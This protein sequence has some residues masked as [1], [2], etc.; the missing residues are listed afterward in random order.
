MSVGSVVLVGGGPGD[1]DL[2][3]VG[4][5]RAIREADVIAYDRLA[6]LEALDEARPDALLIDVG[7]EPH[8]RQT[9]QER[10][11]ELLI[12][13]ALAGRR[14]VRFKG[15]DG[16]VFGRGGEEALACAA[17]GVPVRVIPG[18]SSAIAAPALA[19]IPV[20]HRSIT[21]G[22]TVVSGHVA[23]GDERSTLDW[24]ALARLNTTLVILMG[25]THLPAIASELLVRGKGPEVPAAIVERAGTPGQRVVRA[26]LGSIADAA[27]AHG[28]RPPAIVVVGE[29]AALDLAGV[30]AAADPA[31]A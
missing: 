7:K 1:P 26:T 16:Y 29:V 31:A 12:E 5:L 19:G 17:A 3:T 4:G 22:F 18:V 27:R 13:H 21:Q 11:N 23:P 25:T 9:T 15:G 24:A 10:I 8:G 14:V 28:V 6:P 30:G 20:T 2:L